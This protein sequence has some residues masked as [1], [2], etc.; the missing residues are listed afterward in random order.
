MQLPYNAE[1]SWLGLEFLG[2]TGRLGG[3][4]VN[5][6]HH[7]LLFGFITIYNQLDT[8]IGTEV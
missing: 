2:G 7:Y 8:E 1:D 5:A 6:V 3:R 4:T